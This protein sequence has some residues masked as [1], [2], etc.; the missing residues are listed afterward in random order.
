M[1]P[2]C[3]TISTILYLCVAISCFVQKDYSHGVMWSG[4]TFAN[5]GLLW[6]ELNKI[7]WWT[8]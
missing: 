7:G 4:Y 5:L 6:Y 8:L 2:T 1:G 3:V